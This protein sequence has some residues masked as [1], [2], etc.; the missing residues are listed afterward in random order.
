MKIYIENYNPDKIANKIPALDKHYHSTTRITEIFSDEGI[1][2][3]DS[4]NCNKINIISDGLTKLNNLLIDKSKYTTEISHHI[5]LAHIHIQTTR[6]YYCINPKTKL[7]LVIEGSTPKNQSA[8][9]K[10][11]DFIPTDFYFEVLNEK[12]DTELINNDDLNV[13]LS[14]LN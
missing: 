11:A 5:P 2:I 7:R 6:F 1:F 13:F 14:L 3:I 8:S 9:D 10:Y 4:K 12:T